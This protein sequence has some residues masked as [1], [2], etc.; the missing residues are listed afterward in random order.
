M[1]ERTFN[2]KVHTFPDT[3]TIMIDLGEDNYLSMSSEVAKR[4]AGRMLTAAN[5]AEGNAP[6]HMFVIKVDS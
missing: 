5:E 1:T 3:K 2:P 4:F 6:V